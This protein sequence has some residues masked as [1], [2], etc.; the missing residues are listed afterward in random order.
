MNGDKVCV[1]FFAKPF[2]VQEKVE[3]EGK[4]ITEGINK[5]RSNMWNAVDWDNDGDMDYIV[6]SDSWDDYGWDNA[7]DENGKFLRKLC[8]AHREGC[9]DCI[10]RCPFYK[11]GYVKVKKRYER[12]VKK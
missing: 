11:R 6:G 1:D 4:V 2:E 9:N 12:M 5:F 8:T 10:L 3:Y 7:F